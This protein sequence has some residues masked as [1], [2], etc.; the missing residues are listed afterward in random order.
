M[1]H[2]ET[3]PQPIEGRDY[4][5]QQGVGQGTIGKGRR[6]PRKH[7]T[8]VSI[9][10]ASGLTLGSDGLPHPL[11]TEHDGNLKVR[12]KGVSDLLVEMINL[13][14]ATLFAIAEF[15]DLDFDDLVDKFC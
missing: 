7:V 9:S 12:V 15:A 11:E 14:R 1:A 4:D 3:D 2:T 10:E 13:Q 5:T 8:D 6:G